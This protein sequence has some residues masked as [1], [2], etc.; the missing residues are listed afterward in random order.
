MTALEATTAAAFSAAGTP[1]APSYI[2]A[3]VPAAA[4]EGAG[5]LIFVTDETGGATL[6]YSDGTDWRRTADRA[7]V[8]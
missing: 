1:I 5:A 4:T 7:V 3:E 2:V 6:A 8:S